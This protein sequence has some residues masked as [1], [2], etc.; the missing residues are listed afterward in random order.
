MFSPSLRQLFYL[1]QSSQGQSPAILLG[2]GSSIEAGG[3]TATEIANH[4]AVVLLGGSSDH[5]SEAF[6]K[7]F[8]R[9]LTFESALNIVGGQNSRMDSLKTVLGHLEPSQG[10]NALALLFQRHVFARICLTT[11]YDTIIETAFTK[12]G[13]A[14]KKIVV[15]G[16]GLGDIEAV[17]IF[18]RAT[19]DPVLLVKL[20]G[21]LMVHNSLRC[22]ESEIASLPP[23][24]ARLITEIVKHHGLLIVGYRLKDKGV[25][26][27]V[28]ASPSCHGIYITQVKMTPTVDTRIDELPAIPHSAI[29]EIAGFDHFISH[30]H[31][32][33]SEWDF[34]T[35]HRARLRRMWVAVWSARHNIKARRALAQAVKREEDLLKNTQISE[36]RALSFAISAER[37][38]E[39]KAY[40]CFDKAISALES[41]IECYTAFGS[42]VDS[43]NELGV[44]CLEM[45]LLQLCRERYPSQRRKQTELLFN[46]ILTQLAGLST[47][48]SITRFQ[49][50]LLLGELI[51]ET[52]Y[53]FADYQLPIGMRLDNADRYLGEAE[54]IAKHLGDDEAL[55]AVWRHR[56]IIH[57]LRGDVASN[58]HDQEYHY[59]EWLKLSIAAAAR[60][61]WDDRTRSYALINEAAA[62]LA[63]GRKR[64]DRNDV[65]KAVTIA[66]ASCRVFHK[67]HDARGEGWGHLHACDALLAL[68]EIE[69]NDTPEQTRCL[70]QAMEQAN[71][72]VSVLAVA[73]D[74]YAH[75]WAQ[76]KLACVL[77]K[78]LIKGAHVD[79]LL[80]R[81]IALA[82]S[83]AEKLE[84]S[85][86]PYS[87]AVAYTE[88]A[89]LYLLRASA[90]G[91][92]ETSD[93]LNA[94]RAAGRRVV[95]AKTHLLDKGNVKRAVAQLLNL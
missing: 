78:T 47:A 73:G 25:L 2:A 54:V 92:D 33:F 27:A 90:N 88:L 50:L 38:G 82:N 95:N 94:L 13:V 40:D 93:L 43:V 21:D 10:H 76:L 52:A 67:L 6:H 69:P 34:S 51:K 24:A 89:N 42:E 18:P 37:E 17:P 64:M 29:I 46:R 85:G 30:I 39:L 35:S 26:S 60:L 74:D 80:E 9:D 14:F 45:R 36:I 79:L 59:S 83:V 15:P 72:A 1:L 62:R 16:V 68:V 31:N 44:R 49:L 7:H 61:K 20:H 66:T 28:S 19:T 48:Q 63:Q 55:G 77:H 41:A 84:N 3:R 5:S 12:H 81:A 71:M 11:N 53:Y 70:Q 57:E 4:M 75:L 22:T 58:P 86:Q 91:S 56:A 32:A 8:L 87:A 65:G 23:R